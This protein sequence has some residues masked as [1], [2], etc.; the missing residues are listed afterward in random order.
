MIEMRAIAAE[1]LLK[2]ARLLGRAGG[3]DQERR[4]LVARM[5]AEAVKLLTPLDKQPS[6]TYSSD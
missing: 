6:K 4:D 2:A 3:G 1:Q 5:R